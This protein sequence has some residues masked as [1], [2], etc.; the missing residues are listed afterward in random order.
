MLSNTSSFM[1]ILQLN[2]VKSQKK[3]PIKAVKI[4]R[5]VSV[6][7]FDVNVD[8]NVSVTNVAINVNMNKTKTISSIQNIIS[9]IDVILFHYMTEFCDK[10]S[11]HVLKNI[12]PNRT[13]LINKI[14]E[15]INIKEKIE[16]EKKLD[17]IKRIEEGK[18]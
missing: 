9:N 3:T 6:T 16:R 18:R 12:A 13:E 7:N 8:R 17:A 10:S 1:I 14:I 5:N 11:L 4:P 15:T 2:H